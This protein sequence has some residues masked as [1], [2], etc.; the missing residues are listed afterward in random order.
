MS[1]VLLVFVFICFQF[2]PQRLWG[3]RHLNYDSSAASSGR[4]DSHHYGVTEFRFPGS[5][6]HANVVNHKRNILH[7]LG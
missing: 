5:K 3:W 1:K 4:A 7:C 2:G 6:R